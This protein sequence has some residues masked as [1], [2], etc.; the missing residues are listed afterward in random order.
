MATGHH[1]SSESQ[2]SELNA[3]RRFFNEA[4]SDGPRSFPNGRLSADD[5]GEFAYAIAVDR[6]NGVIKIQFPHPTDWIG[7]RAEDAEAL[8]TRLTEKLVELK[9]G[10]ATY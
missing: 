2:K 10:P 7:L 3:L 9:C 5:D 1:G 6:R 4:V 8:I